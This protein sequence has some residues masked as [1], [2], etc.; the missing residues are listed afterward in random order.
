MCA[1]KALFVFSPLV[2]AAFTA[3]ERD[4][5]AR[6][7]HEDEDDDGEEEDDDDEDEL[8]VLDPEHVCDWSFTKRMQ[9]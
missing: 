9:S 1:V 6:P 5:R 4:V 2:Q 3:N 8:I 7:S